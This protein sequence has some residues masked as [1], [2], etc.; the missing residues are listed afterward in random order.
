MQAA[1]QFLMRVS[2]VS[3]LFV[4]VVVGCCCCCFVAPGDCGFSGRAEDFAGAAS[5][6]QGV[7]SAG[8]WLDASKWGIVFTCVVVVAVVAAV[9][10]VVVVVIVIVV[11][12]QQCG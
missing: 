5:G 7:V 3:S 8:E 11:V 10:V 6:K 9:V 12:V 2:F 4:V 1:P